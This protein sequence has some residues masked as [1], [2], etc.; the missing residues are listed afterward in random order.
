MRY[1][2]DSTRETPIYK[3]V[4]EAI[5]QD[6]RTGVLTAGTKLPTV[7]E[8]AEEMELSM[9]TIKHAYDYLEDLDVIEMTQG[10]GSFVR[11][12]EDS[13]AGSRKD[14][15]MAAIDGLFTELESLGFTP[16]EMEIYINLKLQGLEEKY[17]VVKIAAVDCNPETLQLMESQLS[18]IGYAQV[19]VFSLTHLAELSEKLNT[20]YDLVLTTSSHYSDVEPYIKERQRLAMVAMMPSAETIIRLAQI[21]QDASVGIACASENFAAIVR[22]N[23]STLAPWARTLPVCLFGGSPASHGHSLESLLAECDAVILPERYES[24]AGPGEKALLREYEKK[25]GQLVRYEYRID[26][27]SFLYMEGLIKRIM[28]EKR[29]V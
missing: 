26:R 3:Q 20:S 18:Q 21:P 13:G 28:N 8:L 27:G 4:A 19:A 7:R 11:S 14:R 9:G 17:D 2:I 24:F 15:A 5:L 16:R 1:T 22:T 23:C 6:I 25:G 12:Q 29:S 10:R